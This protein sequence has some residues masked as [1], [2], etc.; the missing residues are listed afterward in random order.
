VRIDS[1]QHFWKFDPVRDAWIDESM[2]NI[3]RDFLPKDLQSI[4]KKNKIDGCVAIQADQ[5]TEETRFLLDHSAKNRFIKGVVGWVDLCDQKVGD[6]LNDYAK[7]PLFKGVRHI[8]QAEGKGFMLRDDFQRGIAQLKDFDLTYDILI[9]PNQLEEAITLVNKNPDQAFVLDHMAKPYIKDKKIIDWSEAILTLGSFKNVYCKL[10]GF[11]TEGNWKSW[12]KSDF[13]DY[14]EIVLKAFGVDRLMF[15]SD[16]PVCLLAAE[17]SQVLEIIE[18]FLI[19][20]SD[21]DKNK[22]MGGNAY[23][24]YKL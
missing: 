12:E 1:H 19:P 8:V 9:Y 10:S 16:W 21:A 13:Q 7:N 23:K 3:K 24:F 20:L 14:L 4:L 2:L 17:Y 22:I 5:S 11:V 15:G 18:D 6:T